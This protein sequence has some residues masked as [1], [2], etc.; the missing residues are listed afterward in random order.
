MELCVDKALA[1]WP[2]RKSCSQGLN[3]QV[4]TSDGWF[5]SGG[6]IANSTI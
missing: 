3:F 5:S 1:V 4:E 2:R 6:S